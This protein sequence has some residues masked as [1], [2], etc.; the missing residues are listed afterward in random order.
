MYKSD[1]EAKMNVILSDVSK[2][3]LVTEDNTKKR[4]ESVKRWISSHRDLFNVDEYDS[5]FP[6]SAAMPVLYGLPKIHKDGTPMRPILS[7]VG[8]Y[9]HGLAT[10]VG[11][12]LGSMRQSAGIPFHLP[13]FLVSH[14]CTR[15]TLSPMM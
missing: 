11:R 5:I 7:M 14:P 4:H 8:S 1:Y 6:H 10:V 3:K 13:N 9:S 12:L 15:H 2:F